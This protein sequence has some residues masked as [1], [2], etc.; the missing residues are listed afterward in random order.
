MGIGEVI[1]AKPVKQFATISSV[2]A[3]GYVAQWF[4][5]GELKEQF[6]KPEEVMGV[7]PLIVEALKNYHP[8]V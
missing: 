3:Q 1:V 7:S 6:F 2:V 4:E 8:K 5:H